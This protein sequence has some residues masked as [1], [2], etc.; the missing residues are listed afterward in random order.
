M[1]QKPGDLPKPPT[2]RSRHLSTN[3]FVESFPSAG[4]KPSVIRSYGER[5]T[6]VQLKKRFGEEGEV[7]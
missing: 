3:V 6:N 1:V 4:L 5:P 2:I 7:G